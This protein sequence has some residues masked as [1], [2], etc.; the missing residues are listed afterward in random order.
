[1]ACYH[2]N[3]VYFSARFDIPCTMYVEPKPG[4][5]ASPR[6]VRDVIAYIRENSVPVLFAANYFSLRQV[7]RVSE[8]AGA[9]AL[10]VAEHV[11]GAPGL[12]TYFDLFDAWIPCLASAYGGPVTSCSR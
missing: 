5:P 1:M 9:T 2:K 8:R 11:E 12:V 6:H 4:I 10:V 3:W 7:E